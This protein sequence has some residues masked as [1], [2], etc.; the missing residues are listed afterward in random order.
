MVLENTVQLQVAVKRKIVGM[1]RYRIEVRRQRLD[2]AQLAG[3]AQQ[4]ILGAVIQPR[5]RANGVAGICA[6]TKLADPPDVDSYAHSL[7]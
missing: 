5:E 1:R 7:V 4:E 6:H 3:N 2:V